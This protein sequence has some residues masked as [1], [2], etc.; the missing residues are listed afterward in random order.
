MKAG[1]VPIHHR[2]KGLDEFERP[3]F[4]GRMARVQRRRRLGFYAVLLA[5]AA[6]GAGIGLL[7]L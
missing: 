5:A 2:L 6:V 4:V 7:I 3:E 1:I